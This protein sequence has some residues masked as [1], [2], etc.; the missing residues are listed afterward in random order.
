MCCDIQYLQS[1]S[2]VQYSTVQYV[3]TCVLIR[4]PA[5]IYRLLVHAGLINAHIAN[6]NGDED[7]RLA[8][9]Y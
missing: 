8:Y 5:C 2:Y 7:N 6:L 1:F 3:V 9:Y 4:I